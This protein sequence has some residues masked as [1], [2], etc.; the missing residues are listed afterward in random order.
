MWNTKTIT[1]SQLQLVEITLHLAELTHVTGELPPTKMM[2]FK[3]PA[4][5]LK[6]HTSSGSVSPSNS[7]ITGA[8][9]LPNPHENLLNH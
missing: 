3:R 8:F 4:Q 2:K 7:T 6:N 5:F 1:N 9:M